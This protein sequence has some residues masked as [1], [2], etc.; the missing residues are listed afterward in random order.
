MQII[1]AVVI[2]LIPIIEKAL[3]NL[4]GILKY[5]FKSKHLPKIYRREDN[6][7]IIP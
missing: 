7:V 1:I 4:S 3:E 5:I 6:A 2:A